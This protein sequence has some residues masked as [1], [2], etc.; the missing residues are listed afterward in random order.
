MGKQAS[1]LL[2]TVC[3]SAVQLLVVAYCAWRFRHSTLF[4]VILTA[5][6]VVT[7]F[8]PRRFATLVLGCSLLAVRV[9]AFLMERDNEVGWTAALLVL[10]TGAVVAWR[11]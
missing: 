10:T 2:M 11:E 6:V 9:A 5:G 1:N 4:V 8:I 7:W 3:L